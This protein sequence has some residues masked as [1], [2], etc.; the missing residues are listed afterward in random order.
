[1]NKILV[2]MVK[3]HKIAVVEIHHRSNSIEAKAIH[4]KFLY[5]IPDIGQKKLQYLFSAVIEKFRIPLAVVSP[6]SGMKILII[7]TVKFIEPFG[8]IFYRMRV[9]QVY[10]HSNSHFMSRIHQLLEV[11]RGAKSIGWRKKIGHVVAKRPVVGMFLNS[12][13]LNGII[14]KFVYTWQHVLGK[15]AV[16]S[17]SLVFL[18]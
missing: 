5:P 4:M 18:R 16:L 8:N 2:V 11:L 13:Q 6:S 9:H 17:Y 14:A 1:M 10:D 3:L 15:L 12:H 7:G